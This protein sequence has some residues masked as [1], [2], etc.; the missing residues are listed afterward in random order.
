MIRFRAPPEAGPAPIRA[1]LK[2][3]SYQFAFPEAEWSEAI[4]DL[5][6]SDGGKDPGSSRSDLSVGSLVRGRSGGEILLPAKVSA[7]GLPP[8]TRLAGHLPD[9][10]SFMHKEEGGGHPP[11]GYRAVVSET[12]AFS[13]PLF[14]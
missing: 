6:P 1:K 13:T 9:H 12:R 3:L 11:S 7:Y 14:T 5:P 2:P 10:P 8:C 4:R